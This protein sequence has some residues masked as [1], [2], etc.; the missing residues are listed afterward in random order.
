MPITDLPGWNYATMGNPPDALVR[1]MLKADAEQEAADEN[2]RRLKNYVQVLA[3]F[4]SNVYEHP[5]MAHEAPPVP[6]LVAPREVEVGQP[7]LVETEL[8]IAEP[9]SD[10]APAPPPPSG[11]VSVVKRKVMNDKGEWIYA[12][13]LDD[14]APNGFE[15]RHPITGD[16]IRKRQIPWGGM[17]V[18][19]P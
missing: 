6:F 1:A 15:T 16:K 9:E 14:T 11:K 12:A 19:I 3:N 2:L 10:Y 5:E 17:Y 8:L 4:K 18:V 13:G 7:V